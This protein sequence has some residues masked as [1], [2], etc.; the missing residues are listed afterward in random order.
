VVLAVG[1]VPV[2]S[3]LVPDT[4]PVAGGPT[5]DLRVLAFS[6]VLTV[7][8][9]LL[10]A[11]LPALRTGGRADL[12]ALRD[13]ARAGGG[14]KERLRAV[15]VTVEIAA[16][17]VLLASS[18][19][20]L[21]AILKVQEL[22]S[23]FR[24]EGV[25]T[26]RTALPSPRYDSVRTRHQ[27]YLAVLERVRA[28]PGVSGAG[29]SSFLPM[30]MGG[31][32]LPVTL[33][34]R[35]DPRERGELASVRLLTPGYFEAMGIER[36]TGRSVSDADAPERPLVAVV[37]ES[38]ARRYRPG[39]NP[40]GK[41]FSI[42]QYER[43][44]VGVVRDVK[45]RGLEREAEPQV[46]L[47]EQQQDQG[48]GNYWPKDLAVRSS[49]PPAALATAIRRIVEAVD[50]EQPISAVQTLNAI[51]ADQTASRAV[52][53][54]VL[55]ALAA[56]AFLLAGIGIHGLL[57]FTVSERTREFG[58]RMALGARGPDVIAMVLRH[59]L[60]LAA[61]GLIPGVVTA[62]WAGRGMQAVLFGVPPADGLT[63]GVVIAL[64]LTMA[65]AGCLAPALR[66]VRVD[67][68][69][70]IKAD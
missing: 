48:L 22:D 58:V 18:G 8:T 20:L 46:Y 12:A 5:V 32:V 50:P 19:L 2:L 39:E 7:A 6:A 59:G 9:C 47:P 44:V 23:G 16:S 14:R 34:G 3:R 64:C 15:L 63:F 36:V 37:S 17:V 25:L 54:R 57:S 52:Q 60:A 66:A 29:Y 56:I 11:V 10:F 40:L 42:A 49:V 55:A 4:R 67:P 1:G 43:E 45:V 61:A 21:R 13:G 38:F 31:G 70:A 35:S 53:L 28:I 62:Y 33:P 65:V 51:V 69:R 27:F 24:P 26:L 30:V 41:R 68:V